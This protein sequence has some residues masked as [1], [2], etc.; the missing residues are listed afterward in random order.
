MDDIVVVQV[1][2]CIQDLFDRLRGILFC[3]LAK[4]A[5]PVKEFS[6]RR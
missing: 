1:V 6:P 2:D 4:L 5:Y 3:K